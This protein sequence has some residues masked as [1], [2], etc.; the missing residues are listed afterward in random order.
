MSRFDTADAAVMVQLDGGIPQR[1]E[2]APPSYCTP[3]PS[4]T[5]RPHL[6]L[7]GGFLGAGKSTAMHALAQWLGDQGLRA[8][9]ITNDQG[10]DLVDTRWLRW[11]GVATEEITGGCFCCRFDDLVGAAGRMRGE[12]PPDVIVAEAVG[13]CTDLVATVTRP[14]RRLHRDQF[15]VAPLSVLVDPHR[16]AGVL[17]LAEG[18]RFSEAVEYIFRRQLAEADLIVVNKADTLDARRRSELLA[19]LTREA[20]RAEVAIVSAR[21]GAGLD[22]WFRRI[23]MTEQADNAVVDV[24]YDRYADGEA[25]LGW[26]NATAAVTAPAAADGDA[27]LES[28]A[29]S[30]HDALQRGGMA[31]AHL[32]MTLGAIDPPGAG[33]GAINL[34]AN[35]L[36]PERSA[37]L[38]A[39]VRAGEL[40][41][42]LR[43]EAAPE[44]L[45][46][47]VRG[48]AAGQIGWSVSLGLV[49]AFRPRRPVPTHRDGYAAE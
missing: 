17:G 40:M 14:L 46:A 44:D 6:I 21:T 38:A 11:C 28:F 49:E 20:P 34:V 8:G 37:S 39:P 42:N 1:A 16:A 25:R 15:T 33:V 3:M 48:A 4:G 30:M 10:H 9:C 31:V 29:A 24:D 18:E 13:S 27:L 12:L 47:V 36:E 43:A 23:L 45:V 19:A 26:L 2:S 5:P 22:D 7:L 41:I 32:K 35:G